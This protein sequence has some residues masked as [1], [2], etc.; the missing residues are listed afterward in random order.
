[1]IVGGVL[2]CCTFTKNPNISQIPRVGELSSY[3]GGINH[4]QP[5][6]LATVTDRQSHMSL[7]TPKGR[8]FKL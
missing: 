3:L 6:T 8:G 7:T 5:L 2:W 1:M 4:E